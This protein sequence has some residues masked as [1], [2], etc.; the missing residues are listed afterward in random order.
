MNTSDLCVLAVPAK[1]KGVANASSPQF[2]EF[3]KES[4][5]ELLVAPIQQS[6][7]DGIG[8]NSQRLPRNACLK[9]LLTQLQRPGSPIPFRGVLLTGS[10]QCL[11]RNWDYA[12]GIAELMQSLNTLVHQGKELYLFGAY[13][14]HLER[15][16][17]LMCLDEDMGIQAW[18]V[19]AKDYLQPPNAAP[20]A[21]GRPTPFIATG[22]KA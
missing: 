11:V 4:T 3:N 18:G 7:F 17:I 12:T 22:R 19:I 15:N 14:R 21:N 10:V 2:G 13:V 6:N 1:G 8:S 9:K 20:K 5:F 16:I